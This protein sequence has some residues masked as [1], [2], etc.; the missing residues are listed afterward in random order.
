MK[1]RSRFLTTPKIVL[2]FC[3]ILEFT[4]ALFILIFWISQLWGFC[5]CFCCCCWPLCKCVLSSLC[6]C[7][8]CFGFFLFFYFILFLFLLFLRLFLCFW[9][10]KEVQFSFNVGGVRVK[11]WSSAGQ[12][13][14]FPYFGIVYKFEV[15]QRSLAVI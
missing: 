5:C 7:C 4:I 8:H 9:S 2:D 6:C 3:F 12:K 1:L 13:N 10:W 14:N 11:L 15:W